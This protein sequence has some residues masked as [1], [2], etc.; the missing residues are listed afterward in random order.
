MCVC[1][2]MRVCMHTRAC[3]CACVFVCVISTNTERRRLISIKTPF[4]LSFGCF[5]LHDLTLFVT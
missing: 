1:V 5:F 4:F 2:C 3:V